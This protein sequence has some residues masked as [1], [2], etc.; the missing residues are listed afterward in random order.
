MRSPLRRRIT[1]PPRKGYGIS[2]RH[3]EKQRA[4]P[5]RQ[6]QRAD[7]SQRDSG[8]PQCHPLPQDQT[9]DRSAVGA[10]R[11]TDANFGC[12][13]LHRIRH[14]PVQTQHGKK[15]RDHSEP[16]QNR[17]LEAPSGARLRY[18]L[19]HR[20]HAGHR[21]RWIDA[22]HDSAELRSRLLRGQC[23]PHH[24]SSGPGRNL[25][26]ELLTCCTET[27]NPPL[28]WKLMR[29]AHAWHNPLH[30]TNAFAAHGK[31]TGR[32]RLGA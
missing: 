17:R 3:F 12:S 28:D 8:E 11:H 5:T 4:D 21:Q 16:S 32:V 24:D 20:P 7:R 10:Q 25:P 27:F 6:D 9:H 18:Q 14:Q 13:F 31:A 2:R 15:H 1:S 22:S 19:G 29:S 23:R 30:S 26:L